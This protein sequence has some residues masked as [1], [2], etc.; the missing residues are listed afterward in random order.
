M[1]NKNKK[2]KNKLVID[3][4]EQPIYIPNRLYVLKNYSQEDIDKLFE[5]DN[6]EQINLERLNFKA[7]TIHGCVEK[8]TDQYCIIVLLSESLLKEAKK[9]IVDGINVCAHE[10]FHAVYSILDWSNVELGN[11][12]NETFA[13]MTGWA[14]KCIY[15]TL[16]K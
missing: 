2:K 10:A 1:A 4:Y 11:D 16:K 7:V 6:G 13:F 12:S 3:V 5:Y 14:T 15:K 8:K 9:N